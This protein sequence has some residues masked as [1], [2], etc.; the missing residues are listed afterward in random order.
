VPLLDKTP[1]FVSYYVVNSKERDR[2]TSF[3]VCE[4]QAAMDKVNQ[5]ALDWVK[6][7]LPNTLSDPEVITGELP[8]ALTHAHV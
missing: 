1:G 8:I 7:A 5:I 6:R 3:T 4:N 2:A